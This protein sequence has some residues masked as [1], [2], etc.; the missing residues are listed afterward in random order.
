M[1]RPDAD[2]I[3][4]DGLFRCCVESIRTWGPDFA[5]EGDILT[6]RVGVG[7]QIRVIYLNGAWEW[8][9]P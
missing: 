7:C 8:L 1:E 3:R 6:C 4:T 5:E 9:K 2:P